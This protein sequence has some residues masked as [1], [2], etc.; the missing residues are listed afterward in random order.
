MSVDEFYT[1]GR[2]TIED[3]DSSSLDGMP[4]SF[5]RIGEGGPSIKNNP[6]STYDLYVLMTQGSQKKVGDLGYPTKFFK[7]REGKPV[8]AKKLK[9]ENYRLKVLAYTAEVV[10]QFLTI[11]LNEEILYIPQVGGLEAHGNKGGKSGAHPWG[12]AWDHGDKGNSITG[13][14]TFFFERSKKALSTTQVVA[15][16]A[17]CV[18]RGLLLDG[19]L[20]MYE[21]NNVIDN[22]HYDYL[23]W[24]MKN[25]EGFSDL[26][27]KDTRKK[28]KW[29]TTG[30]LWWPE[31]PATKKKNE[32]KSADVYETKKDLLLWVKKK[33]P[34]SQNIGKIIELY[35]SWFEL[36]NSTNIITFKEYMKYLKDEGNRWKFLTSLT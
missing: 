9:E 28:S 22:M 35:E 36:G 5:E 11:A 18:D 27:D 20:G 12:L 33:R 25:S 1:L 29:N 15:A 2:I 30:W 32:Y 21:N 10:R 34:S 24:R 16:V 4:K 13:F 8:T 3:I 23:P 14:P 17:V 26:E 6:L 19:R 31:P 7:S